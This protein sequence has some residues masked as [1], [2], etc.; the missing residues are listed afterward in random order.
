MRTINKKNKKSFSFKLWI[1]RILI[2]FWILCF[3]CFA[4]FC[5]WGWHSGY[6]QKKYEKLKTQY[7]Q[8]MGNAGFVLNDIL[9]QG[10]VRTSKTDIKNALNL[11]VEN[12]ILTFD[13]NQMQKNLSQLPWIKEVSVSRQLPDI[14]FIRLIERTPIA[15]WQKGNAY[16]PLDEHGNLINTNCEECVYLPLV[17][18]ENAPKATP[19]LI[20]TLN[21]FNNLKDRVVSAVFINNRRWNLYIDDIQNGIIVLL[22]EADLMNSLKRLD[23]LQ[24]TKKVLDRDIEKID[25]RF[26]DKTIIKP[27]SE[28]AITFPEKGGKE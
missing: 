3:I 9:I 10:R 27:K 4:G 28:D 16:F 24:Q 19:E 8:M 7:H 5:V 22:P 26:A 1:H 12:L 2:C 17:V 6:I 18:G 13:L 23:T 15:L 25:L 20:E 14:L 11:P 21:K